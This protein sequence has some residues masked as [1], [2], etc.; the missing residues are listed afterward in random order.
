MQKPKK[1][2][3][4]KIFR[5]DLERKRLP[6]IKKRFAFNVNVSKKAGEKVIQ[7]A[8]LSFTMLE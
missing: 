2:K 1:K 6:P 5:C 8:T 3:K 4:K 7:D